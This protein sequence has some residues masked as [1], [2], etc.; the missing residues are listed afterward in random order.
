MFSIIFWLIVTVDGEWLN[1]DKWQDSFFNLFIKVCLSVDS[2]SLNGK[3]MFGYQG[4][5]GTDNDGLPG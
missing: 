4:W 1:K 3:V 2:N 5:F